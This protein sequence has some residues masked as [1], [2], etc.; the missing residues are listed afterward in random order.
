[1]I[2]STHF[3]MI[4][5]VFCCLP[6]KL[7]FQRGKSFRLFTFVYSTRLGKGISRQ[8]D[9]YILTAHN[10]PLFSR[11]YC[12]CLVSNQCLSSRLFSLPI[13]REMILVSLKKILLPQSHQGQTSGFFR[14]CFCFHEAFKNI[15]MMLQWFLLIKRQR[16]CG[17]GSEVNIR[18]KH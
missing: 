10:P 5:G 13:H 18:L 4:S 11:N 15:L 9:I 2:Y 8:L 6:F 12:D 7:W 14:F 17:R 16:R 1:M 3:S